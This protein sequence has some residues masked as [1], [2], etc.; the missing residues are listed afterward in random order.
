MDAQYTVL[1]ILIVEVAKDKADKHADKVEEF[2][3]KLARDTETKRATPDAAVLP[4]H[5]DP[6]ILLP[7]NTDEFYR[8]QGSLTTKHDE[9]NFETVRWVIYRQRKGLTPAALADYRTIAHQAKRLQ[10]ANR[11]FVL[12]NFRELNAGGAM[13]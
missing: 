10:P 1:G 9:D 6:K 5:L 7:N 13:A 11:R 4:T 8:Y 3:R 2:F 12:R